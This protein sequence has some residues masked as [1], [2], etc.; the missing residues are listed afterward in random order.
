TGQRLADIAALTWENLDLSKNEIRL[1]TR[2]TAKRIM[3]PIAKPL[4]QHI[5]SLPAGFQSGTPIHPK[6]FKIINR[7]GRSANLS[8]HFA[9]LLAKAG[10]RERAR[11]NWGKGKGGRG[12]RA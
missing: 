9:D 1:R 3:V 8:N 2:K 5:D 7:H 6:A 11:H 10:L 4:R 12:K